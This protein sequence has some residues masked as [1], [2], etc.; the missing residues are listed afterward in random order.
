MNLT[1]I[2]KKRKFFI[3]GIIIAIIILSTFFNYFS[4]NY[5]GSTI[6]ENQYN[7]YYLIGN[8]K[9]IFEKQGGYSHRFNIKMNSV[10]DKKIEEIN[11]FNNIIDN[12]QGHKIIV[13]NI[14]QDNSLQIKVYNKL[15][16]K[17]GILAESLKD[18]ISL[19][20]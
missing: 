10:L 17:L 2:I 13:K 11:E 8:K 18:F 19:F 9:I 20:S 14:N 7:S 6:M 4:L 3:P 1:K 15:F 16:L 5:S 12:V